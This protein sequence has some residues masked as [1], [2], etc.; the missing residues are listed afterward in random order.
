[1]E[2]VLP[3]GLLLKGIRRRLQAAYVAFRTRDGTLL[4]NGLHRYRKPVEEA[5]KN[6]A[7]LQSGLHFFVQGE[8]LC[9]FR[10]ETLGEHLLWVSGGPLRDGEPPP[11]YTLNPTERRMLLSVQS[12]EERLLR[13]FFFHFPLGVVFL[14]F[15]EG[16]ILFW[17][18]TM[19]ALTGK[20]EKE[21]LGRRWDEIF[22]QE[23]LDDM[24]Q[25][26]RFG[27]EYLV[28]NFRLQRNSALNGDRLLNLRFFSWQEGETMRVVGLVEDVTERARW[29]ESIRQME[30][31]S[32]I[33][34]FISSMAHE[35]NNPLGVIYGY[36]QMLLAQIEGNSNC[37]TCQM[38]R[39]V[40]EK[41]ER[42]AAHCSEVIRYLVDFSRPL[43]LQRE[44]TDVN[45]LL[46]ESLALVDFFCTENERVEFALEENLPLVPVD[47][48]RMRQVFMNLAKNAFEAMRE[49]GGVLRISTES[50]LLENVP[51]WEGKKRFSSYVKVVFADT[52]KGIPET[53]LPRIFEPFFT[54]K[55]RG[56]GLGLSISYGIVRAHG[57]WIEVTSKE[58]V[59][60]KVQVFLP[61]ER[62]SEA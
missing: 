13:L 4:Y 61:V 21:V 11:V 8:E 5:L 2:R 15:G 52:G 17:N 14:S 62:G 20:R 49:R 39:K 34:R 51:P 29:G 19:E 56:T 3:W 22:P 10:A 55:E 38:T 42:E 36:T 40:L 47:R 28:R 1:M 37:S 32:S 53:L 45:T 7:F 24:W 57:G 6:P 43:V 9:F 31:L 27:E 58:G 18:S 54:T 16:R 48:T 50:V 35:I 25:S 60:T 46:R 44:P 59:G 23:T 33:G 26:L 12:I 41:I 30:R